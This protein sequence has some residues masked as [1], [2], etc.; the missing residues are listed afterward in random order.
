M[1]SPAYHSPARLHGRRSSVCCG[2]LLALVV[3]AAEIAHGQSPWEVSPYQIKVWLTIECHPRIPVEWHAQLKQQLEMQA[4]SQVGA[5]WNLIAEPAPPALQQELLD[6]RLPDWQALVD[7]DATLRQSDKLFVLKLNADLAG[8]GVQVRELDLHTQIWSLPLQRSVNSLE[9]VPSVAF[10]LLCDTFVP[11]AQILKVRDENVTAVLRAGALLRPE[12]SPRSWNVPTR[13]DEGQVLQPVI[14]R[15]D[16]N[17]QVTAG[18]ARP[19]DWTLLLVK[20]RSDSTLECQFYSGY[21]QPFSTRRS[22]RVS[23]LAFLVKPRYAATEL[24][25]IDRQNAEQPLVGYEIYSRPP[26]SESSVFLGRSDWRGRL[27]IASDAEHPVRVLFVRSGTQ[28]LGKLP[29][30]PAPQPLLRG[31]FTQRRPAIGGRRVLARDPGEPGRPGRTSRS[32]QLADP[33]TN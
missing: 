26:G 23:Q 3:S 15:S 20:S 4:A 8:Y 29:L 21:R 33:E 27:S 30:V 11:V 2:L 22:A 1:R 19:I 25:L 18:G 10:E 13:I 7:K 31:P 14:V 5:V 9:Q 6:D 12:P 24:E 16:R 17:G 28:L 32:P